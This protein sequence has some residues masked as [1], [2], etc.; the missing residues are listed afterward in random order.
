MEE[1]PP[2]AWSWTAYRGA[3]KIYDSRIPSIKNLHLFRENPLSGSTRASRAGLGALAG[4]NFAP[5]CRVCF[6]A[7][8]SADFRRPSQPPAHFGFLITYFTL[9]E[10]RPLPEAFFTIPFLIPPI[11]SVAFWERMFFC[12]T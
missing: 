12:P 7:R 10:G 4:T 2:H 3:H 5:F 9:R 1:L 6:D 11:L 8:K